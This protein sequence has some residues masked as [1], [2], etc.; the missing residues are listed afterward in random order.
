MKII[1]KKIFLFFC[2]C[3]LSNESYSQIQ[4]THL[5]FNAGD[6]AV[7]QFIENFTG[8]CFESPFYR[9]HAV[10]KIAEQAKLHPA[11]GQNKER[12]LMPAGG[13]T[14]RPQTNSRQG[15]KQDSR[16]R[17]RI[18]PDASPGQPS[19]NCRRPSACR[20]RSF[21]G[22]SARHNTKSC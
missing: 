18:G 17:N 22:S 4:F 7:G 12:A 9:H 13:F 2:L 6:H 15:G 19:R 14:R 3:F 20:V 8:L 21:Q 10:E 11:H 5:W 16:H 1:S